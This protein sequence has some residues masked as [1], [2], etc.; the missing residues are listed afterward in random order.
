MA[1][2]SAASVGMDGGGISPVAEPMYL[3]EKALVDFIQHC[4][5]IDKEKCIDD[6]LVNCYCIRGGEGGGLASSDSQGS[7]SWYGDG[8]SQG[9]GSWHGDGG[10]G[11]GSAAF[12]TE[13]PLEAASGAGGGSVVWTRGDDNPYVDA[14]NE[15]Y[16]CLIHK[17]QEYCPSKIKEQLNTYASFVFLNVPSIQAMMKALYQLAYTIGGGFGKRMIRKLNDL[18]NPGSITALDAEFYINLK[19]LLVKIRNQLRTEAEAEERER[20]MRA[21]RIGTDTD[22]GRRDRQLRGGAWRGAAASSLSSSG[23]SDLRVRNGVPVGRA[24]GAS[25]GGVA[26][27]AQPAARSPPMAGN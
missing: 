1:A 21:M 5:A 3:P 20:G 14:A 17:T 2:A 26:A 27:T 6:K 25:S 16:E 23:G 13:Q 24:H 18:Q 19:E 9:S 15:L 10:S 11:G 7:G 8:D 12:T 4:V 22:K